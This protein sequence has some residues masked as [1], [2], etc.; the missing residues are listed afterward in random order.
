MNNAPK[1]SMMH[2]HSTEQNHE[3]HEEINEN[4]CGALTSKLSLLELIFHTQELQAWNALN[5]IEHET[6]V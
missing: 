4:L 3:S 1:Q 5:S 6:V 2:I